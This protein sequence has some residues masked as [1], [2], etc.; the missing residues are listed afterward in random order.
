LTSALSAKRHIE[1]ALITA[2]RNFF[3]LFIRNI[4]LPG[5]VQSTS[6]IGLVLKISKKKKGNNRMSEN[7]LI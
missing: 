2:A 6:I 4:R 7:R 5:F 1:L 3:I